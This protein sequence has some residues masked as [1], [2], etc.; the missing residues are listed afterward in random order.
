MPGATP[1]SPEGLPAIEAAIWQ[2]LEQAA[3]DRQHAW[4]A[5]ALATVGNGRAQARIVLL[6]EAHERERELLCFTDARSAKVEQLRAQPLGT[7]L[8]WSA[9]LGWQLRLSVRLEVATSGLRVSSHWARIKQTPA[10]QD[11][12]APLPPGSALSAPPRPELTSRHH[13]ALISARVDE[14]DWLELR[15]QGHRRARFGADGARWLQP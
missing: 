8:L 11:Y 14:I 10:A 9:A 4:R 7:L 6:R 15:D 5:M 2:H 12:L 3:S 1:P 13:F